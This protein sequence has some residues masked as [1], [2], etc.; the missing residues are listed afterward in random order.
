MKSMFLMPGIH[1]PRKDF[2][3]GQGSRLSLSQSPRL[4]Q[5]FWGD[6]FGML[7]TAID[8]GTDI[9]LR[10]EDERIAE[11]RADAIKARAAA[12][13]AIANA[14]AN[15]ALSTNTIAGIDKGTFIIGAVGIGLVAIIAT[16]A[17]TR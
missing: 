16:I 8:K 9:Y 3:M 4:G 5:D 7:P 6:L 1:S 14:T 13:V 2:F 11:E 10:T 15:A 12:D 17:L